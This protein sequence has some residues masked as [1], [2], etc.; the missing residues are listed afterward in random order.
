MCSSTF[1]NLFLNKE[2]YKTSMIQYIDIRFINLK[3]FQERDHLKI[4]Y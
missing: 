4:I 1:W 3:H 2:Y